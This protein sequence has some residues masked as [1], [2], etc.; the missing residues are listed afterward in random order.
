[1]NLRDEAGMTLPEMLIALA[2]SLVVLLATLSL[3]D[4]GNQ[5]SARNARLAQSTAD[6]RGAMHALTR[7]MRNATS[8]GTAATAG[9]GSVLAAGALDVTFKEVSPTATSTV[10]N[11]AGVQSVR[12]CL[13][14][15]ARLHRQ[16]HADITLPASACPDPAWTDAIAA[17]NIRNTVATP[18]FTYDNATPD[19]VASVGVDLRVDDDPARRPA[20]VPLSSGVQLRNQN[21]PP[22]AHFG[23]IAS[24]GRR[25]E[26]NGSTSTDP[27]GGVM[28][29][30]VWS[31]GGTQLSQ[32]GPVVDDVVPPEDV[33]PNGV[34]TYELTVIDNGGLRDTISHDV[35]VRP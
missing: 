20:A 5:V 31:R 12:Y 3:L 33:P 9:G 34:V 23:A 22:T 19:R 30:F 21:R 26:L 28:L 1:M 14:G 18:I 16:T 13:D 29:T 11:P 6:A 35:T 7:E 32:S 15:Q 4:S 17:T 24:P 25:V 2:I 10:A 27:E 8:T